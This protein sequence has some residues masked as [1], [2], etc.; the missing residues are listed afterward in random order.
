MNH[1]VRQGW[2]MADDS[3]IEAAGDNKTDLQ[4][5]SGRKP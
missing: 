3:L 4:T 5:T 1:A 2:C